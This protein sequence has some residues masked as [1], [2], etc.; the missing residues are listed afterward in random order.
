MDQGY[1]HITRPEDAKFAQKDT[2]VKDNRTHMASVTNDDTQTLSGVGVHKRALS[3]MLRLVADQQTTPPSLEKVA[4][5]SD[6][7]LSELQQIFPDT[8]SLLVALAEEG[9][10]RLV[11]G[12]TKA[13]V[14]ID[15]NDAMAQFGALGEAYITWAYENPI[16]FRLISGA[17]LIDTTRNPQLDR[18]F[19]SVRHLMLR[20]LERARDAGLLHPDEDIP[21]LAL[22]SRAYA[23]GIA[24]MVVDLR[25][26]EWD[27]KRDPLDMARA[28]IKDFLQRIARGSRPPNGNK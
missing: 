3:S 7:P 23:Y 4:Q 2:Q 18:Y 16:Q 27:P 26:R 22:T 21:Q 5:A 10:M 9:L 6:V 25:M 1:R 8:Q 24:R 19:Q 13:V 20:M 12:C 15:P 11:D 17:Q 28:S 14:Q